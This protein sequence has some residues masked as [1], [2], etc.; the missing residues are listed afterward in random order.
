MNRPVLIP[1][2]H[3]DNGESGRGGSPCP[4]REGVVMRRRNA[5]TFYDPDGNEINW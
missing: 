2:P 1:A 4:V 3:T 5:E